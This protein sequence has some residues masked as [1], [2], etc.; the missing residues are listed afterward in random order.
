[1]KLNKISKNL[2]LH[3]ISGVAPEN[4]F[5]SYTILYISSGKE[6]N[7][8]THITIQNLK[9]SSIPLLLSLH[10][11]KTNEYNYFVTSGGDP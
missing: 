8:P 9:G 5:I 10:I 3:K 2:F 4:Q 11:I 7:K 1:M 6:K